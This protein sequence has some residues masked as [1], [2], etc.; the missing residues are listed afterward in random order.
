MKENKTQLFY[1]IERKTRAARAAMY[2]AAIH[3]SFDT[4]I[5]YNKAPETYK[6]AEKEKAARVL[7]FFKL[8]AVTECINKI[9]SGDP[10]LE[11]ERA[12]IINCFMDSV[13]AG[14]GKM[15]GIYS[16]STAVFLNPQCKKNAAT[17]GSICAHCYASRYAGMRPDLARKLEINTELYT[18]AIIPADLLPFINAAVIRLESFGDLNNSIQ[19]LNYFEI[20]R[21]NSHAR[22]ALWTKNPRFIDQLIN[23]GYVKPENLSIVYSALFLNTPDSDVLPILNKYA[24]IDYVFIVYTP[25]YIKENNIAINCGGRHCLSCLNCYKAGNVRIIREKKK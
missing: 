8:A 24:F 9:L 16:I 21:K 13:T 20:C 17:P 18:R 7:H 12:F 15:T 4:A 5:I 22:I 19:V 3:E 10:L 14:S 6:N 23:I 1:S 25:E 2:D 11:F